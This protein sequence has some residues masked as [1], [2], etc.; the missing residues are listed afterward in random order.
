MTMNIHKMKDDEL[1]VYWTELAKEGSALIKSGT[2]P[3]RL[4]DIFDEIQK[5]R[6]QLFSR[7]QGEKRNEKKA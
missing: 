3:N 1:A 4:N 6:E 5:I 7:K 2:E